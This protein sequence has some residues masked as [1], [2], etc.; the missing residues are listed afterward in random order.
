MRFKNVFKLKQ[1]E[2]LITKNKDAGYVPENE[3]STELELL[4]NENEQLKQ[5][6]MAQNSKSSSSA[7]E[8]EIQVKER[9]YQESKAR[10]NKAEQEI[11]AQKVL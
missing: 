1:F 5:Q 4:R 3:D 8:E 6:L 10:A 9:L 11:E 2:I 7:S